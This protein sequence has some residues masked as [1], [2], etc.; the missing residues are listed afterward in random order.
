[1]TETELL[2]ATRR[3]CVVAAAG[4]GKTQLIVDTVKAAADGRTLILT[5]TNA[6]VDAIR[7][8]LRR[9]G[10]P[11][12]GVSVDTL[13]GWCLRYVA[14]Y[15]R[16]SGAPTSKEDGGIDWLGLRRAMLVLLQT[17]LAEK[18]LKASY[19]AVFV[20]EYQDCEQNQHALI[21]RVADILPTRVVGDPLQA[22]FN[23]KGLILPPWTDVEKVFPRVLSLETPW[24]WKK[25]GANPGLGEWLAHARAKIESGGM[26]DLTDARITLV[27][28]SWNDWRNVARQKCFE[29]ADADRDG[30]IVTV[31]KWPGDSRDVAKMS[32]G[33]F[34]M[35]ETVEARD[36]VEH[37]VALQTA[38]PMERPEILLRIVSMVAIRFDEHASTIRDAMSGRPVDAGYDCVLAALRDVERAGPALVL[39]EALDALIRLPRVAVFRR[40]LV[41]AMMDALRD[42]GAGQPVDLDLAFR[43]RRSLASSMGRRLARCSVG[44]TLLVKGMEFDHGIVVHTGGAKGFSANNLY[45]ALT[46]AS[47]SLTI[48]TTSDVVDTFSLP[49]S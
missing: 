11:S 28:T 42:V 13:D 1:M 38:V 46:R 21:T 9:E 27:R 49:D 4:C 10:V 23:F 7:R 34:Q 32:G 15:P 44:T 35:I 22:I 43:K 8:R 39:A 33:R 24:R 37:L 25:A 5:H 3:G 20:D 40:E 29:L 14:S 2:A 26:L 48:V 41:W 47:T 45:V 19:N 18:I 6:A 17:R 16:L 31:V 12:A 36:A 30:T